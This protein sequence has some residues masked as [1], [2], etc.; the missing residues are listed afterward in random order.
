MSELSFWEMAMGCQFN[1][2]NDSDVDTVK[3]MC[4][5]LANKLND[6]RQQAG[7]WE[8]WRMLSVAITELQTAQMRAV[9]AITWK[10]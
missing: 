4:A 5:T 2:S 7:Q 10:Y 1:P 9:K 8:K 3:Q 6:L